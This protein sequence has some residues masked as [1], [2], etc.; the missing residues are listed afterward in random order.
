MMVDVNIRVVSITTGRVPSID[1]TSYLLSPLAFPFTLAFKTITATGASMRSVYPCLLRPTW[2]ERSNHIE[3]LN[4]AMR[5]K[6][7]IKADTK[8]SDAILRRK[9]YLQAESICSSV[10]AI[11]K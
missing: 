7:I 4:S 6:S 2:L 8:L 11:K 5:S 9:K 1:E 10:L 3:R